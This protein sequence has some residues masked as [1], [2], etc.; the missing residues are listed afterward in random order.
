MARPRS[1]ND[2]QINRAAREVFVEHG[3]SASVSL[4]ARR[5]GVSHAALFGRAGSKKQLMLDALCPGR[6]RALE[7]LSEPP[8]PEGAEDRLAEILVELMEFLQRV[9]PNLVI[10]RV[11]GESMDSLPGAS[12][13]PP[14]VA[15]RRALA[16]WLEAAA[17]DGGIPPVH[18]PSV[19]EGL[20][21]A[22]EARC[23]NRYLGGEAFA[24]GDDREFV[25]ELL[26][27]LLRGL[28]GGLPG[29][30]PGGRHAQGPPRAGG[31]R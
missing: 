3:P 16:G 17:C 30:L 27:G 10:L 12:G 23:F 31:P 20:L 24:P 18:A 8:P 13:P 15:L 14:P 21:G 22:M 11:A 7:W 25:E 2:D 28:P 29:E 9:V 26:R 4:I 1:V 19:A 5:L 6:P